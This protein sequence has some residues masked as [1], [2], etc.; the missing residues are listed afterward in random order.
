MYG[1]I[2]VGMCYASYGT[3][4]HDSSQPQRQ[5]RS[6]CVHIIPVSYSHIH[7]SDYFKMFLKNPELCLTVPKDRGTPS[8]RLEQ[9][10]SQK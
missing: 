3:L 1:Y 6:K 10:I 5:S 7:M 4:Y 9:F 2:S 8:I